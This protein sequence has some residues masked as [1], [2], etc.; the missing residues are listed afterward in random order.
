MIDK[1]KTIEEENENKT[2]NNFT[3]LP[4]HPFVEKTYISTRR[5]TIITELIGH[6]ISG[7]NRC[8][9]S[10]DSEELY[11]LCALILFK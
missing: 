4:E 3:L 1:S 5:R 9:D 11:T 2:E 8:H 10:E 6:K 7:T